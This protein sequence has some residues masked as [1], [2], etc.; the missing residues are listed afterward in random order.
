MVFQVDGSVTQLNDNPNFSITSHIYG[1]IFSDFSE[2]LNIDSYYIT[3]QNAIEKIKS[4]NRP[5]FS[6]FNLNCRS[7]NSCFTELSS[8]IDCYKNSGVE[9]TVINLQESWL[10]D[11]SNLNLI[12]L[13]GYDL[14]SKPRP[15]GR[16]GA[17]ALMCNLGS[18][19]KRFFQ[20][21]L[22]NQSLSV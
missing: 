18:K 5:V 21:F 14:F 6:I 1:D 22:N 9:P 7:I 4:L 3:E 19:L 11:N 8:S 16:G 10:N 12:Q 13:N 15:Q 17:F 20:I 2:E